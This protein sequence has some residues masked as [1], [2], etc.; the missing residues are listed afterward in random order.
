MVIVFLLNH[1]VIITLNF[2]EGVSPC[3]AKRTLRADIH[4]V[5]PG[6][7]PGQVWSGRCRVHARGHGSRLCHEV[8]WAWQRKTRRGRFSAG[9]LI[10]RI[11]E[12]WLGHIQPNLSKFY[13]Q[14]RQK[15]LVEYRRC[16]I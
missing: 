11:R 8:V 5:F 15:H 9:I 1:T 2:E 4:A 7:A 6:T 3:R 10:T 16:Q 13:L 12:V 14:T